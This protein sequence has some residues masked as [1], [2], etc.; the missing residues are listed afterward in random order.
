MAFTKTQIAIAVGTGALLVFVFLGYLW[1]LSDQGPVL[2]R[3]EEHDPL[4]GLP[5]SIKMN[6]FRDRSTERA[7]NKFLR[8]MRDGHCDELLSK[9]EHD[10]HKKYAH[11][12]CQSEAQHPLISWQLADWEDAP[13]F[14]ILHYR[15]KRLSNAAPNQPGVDQDLFT[16]TMAH[17][18]AEWTVT[19]YDA[20]Y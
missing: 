18:G 13:P 11:F 2:A 10:Y 7:A 17:E 3:S 1:W 20:M 19:K 14:V 8:D 6:P 5:F 12:I 9:W 4:T 16:L 15:G